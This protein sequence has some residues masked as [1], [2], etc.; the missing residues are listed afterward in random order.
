MYNPQNTNANSFHLQK[1]YVSRSF[2]KY[3][4]LAIAVIGGLG[5]S[6]SAVAE[7]QTDGE[8]VEKIEVTGRA[9]QFYLDSNTRVGTKTDADI[10]EIP[11]Y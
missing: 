7:K 11:L 9:Q 2:M 1:Y 4:T 6:F 5:A 10:M 8:N 3:S